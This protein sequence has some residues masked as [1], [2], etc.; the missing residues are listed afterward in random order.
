MRR[1]TTIFELALAVSVVTV[2]AW[3]LVPFFAHAGGKT[4]KASCT[5]N[6]QL[7]AQ[8]VLMYSHDHDDTLPGGA[9]MGPNGAWGPAWWALIQPYVKNHSV[10]VCPAQVNPPGAYDTN[11]PIS[12]GCNPNFMGWQ[13]G[14]RIDQVVSP[15]GTIML[16]EKSC[17]DWAV[18]PSDSDPAGPDGPF[19]VD[20][21]HDGGANYAFLD[22]RV[23]WMK[24]GD[25]ST[26]VNLWINR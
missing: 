17:G 9:G 5:G 21:R 11:W 4:R 20:C 2:T 12:Y 15:P 7:L 23:H 8:A 14:A 18:F 19:R 24:K 13:K 26:P 6:L 1:G 3:Y 10:L 16:G 22:G 25:D